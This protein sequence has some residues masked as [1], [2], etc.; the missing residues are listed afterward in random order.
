LWRA[1]S[2]FV[3]FL[4][5]K[6]VFFFIAPLAIAWAVRRSSRLLLCVLVAASVLMALLTGGR[7]IVLYP[8]AYLAFGL[9]FAPLPV[10]LLRR[11]AF[12]VFLIAI[13]LIPSIQIYRG[14]PEFQQSSRFS[15]IQRLQ[16]LARAT[17]SYGDLSLASRL[18]TTGGS[19]YACS[20]SYLFIEPAKSAPRA[21]AAR[22]NRIWQAWL[23]TMLFPNKPP[24]RDGHIVVNEILGTPRSKAETMSYTSFACISFP[25]DLYWRGGWGLVVAGSFL[26][27]LFYRLL[28]QCW[29]RWAGL[30]SLVGLAIWVYPATFFIDYPAGSVG[31][32]LWI[33]LWDLP[34]YIVLVAVIALIQ[35]A[36]QR[37]LQ[38]NS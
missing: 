20:D 22:L 2:F 26:F 8:L 24:L 25:A 32:T 33:W 21:G 17:T 10:K 35:R 7:G 16:L 1:D 37:R 31:E 18:E 4:K 14:L 34:K 3:I 9:W 19:L 36:W 5:L 23:P 29:Y 38:S 28:A 12:I 30:S 13:L 11:W 6:N 15:V 27:A